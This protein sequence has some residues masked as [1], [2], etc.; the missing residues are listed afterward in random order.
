MTAPAF[1]P[2]SQQPL[3]RLATRSALWTGFSQYFFFGLGFIKTIILSRLVEPEYFG[4][5]AVAT[6]WSSYFAFGRLELRLA[7]FNSAEEPDVLNTQFLLENL[8]SLLGFIVAGAVAVLWPAIAPPGTW[9]LIFVLLIVGLFETI[10]STPRYVAE[11]RLRQDVLGRLTVFTSLVGF[12]VPIGL[13]LGGAFLPALMMDAL[14]PSLIVGAGAALFIRW[15][16]TLLW[17][18]TQIRE[19]LWLGWTLWSSGLLGKITFQFDDWL[20]GNF[21]RPN[22]LPW[23]AAG[24][25]PEGYYSRAYNVGKMPMDVAAG[26][27]GSIALSLY[28]EGAARGREILR[29]VYQQVTWALAWIIL[30]S[31]AVAFVTADEVVTLLLGPRWLPMAPLFRLMFLFVV[32]RPFFQ[33][34]AQLL[35]A[36]RAER[37]FRWT[38]AV[39]A[40]F[41]VLACPPAVYFYGAAGAS[42]VVSVMSVIGL[43]AAEWRVSKQLGVSA[44]RVYVVPALAGAAVIGTLSL[45]TPAM[46]QN[47]WLAAI[48]KSLLCAAVFG[49][50]LLIFERKSAQTAWR[51]L[52]Q[53]LK[54]E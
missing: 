2:P 50:A 44:W 5:L 33:N 15:R 28:A 23:L 54:R 17:D 6:V 26:M 9:P 36:L 53:G 37:D 8:S 20:V 10:T 24:I 4:L 41:I 47:L 34:N 51:T 21:Q 22:P 49:A 19:Q 52:R 13:A 35:L 11:K 3:A 43:V 46:P 39:Q 31:S 14:L 32:G 42:V 40:I 18:R 48:V 7:V 30:F 29:A 38:M 45:L 27:I 1:P 12:V 16:P 25:V